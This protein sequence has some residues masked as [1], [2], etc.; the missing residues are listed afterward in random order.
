MLWVGEC[1]S[2]PRNGTVAAREPGRCSRPLIAIRPVPP[3]CRAACLFLA[4]AFSKIKEPQTQF[5][6]PLSGAT[7]PQKGTSSL[8]F[9][10]RTAKGGASQF[11]EDTTK[12]QG[13]YFRVCESQENIYRYADTIDVYSWKIFDDLY[14]F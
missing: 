13:G 1:A 8:Q 10:V 9:F 12:F 3:R 4:G 6:A 7:F 14:D 11:A 5:P 2:G